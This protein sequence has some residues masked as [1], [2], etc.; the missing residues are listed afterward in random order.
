MSFETKTAPSATAVNPVLRDTFRLLAIM[1]AITTG[2]GFLVHATGFADAL[3]LI[4]FYGAIIAQ[5]V[6]IFVIHKASSKPGAASL[7]WMFVFAALEGLILEAII[8]HVAA[9]DSGAVGA[10]IATT[11]LVFLGMTY[12]A[13]TTQRDLSN[14]GSY[15]MVALLAL[16]GAIIVNL[17]VGS[18]MLSMLISIGASIVFSLFILFDVNQIVRGGETNYV[19]AALGLFISITGLF[20][21][22]LSLF[23]ND[24]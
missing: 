1:F 3:G 16:I 4:G 13:Q 15:L 23:S 5:L 7:N 18:S 24:D 9:I 17:F 22:L 6:L 10:A 2:T 11:A 14:M 21:H 12:V 20:V 8:S 19:R